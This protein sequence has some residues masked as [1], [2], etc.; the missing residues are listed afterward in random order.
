MQISTQKK[1]TG[2]IAPKRFVQRV[3]K[4]NELF[5]GYMHQDA[6]EF[7]NFLLNDLVDILEKEAA[8]GPAE[9]VSPPQKIVNGHMV[10]RSM[11]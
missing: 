8:K 3:K 2:V 7:L 1:K 4:E 6:H 9:S 5:R 10:I 11:V